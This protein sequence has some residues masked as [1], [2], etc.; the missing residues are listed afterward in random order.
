ME[1]CEALCTKLGI[2]VNGQFQCF[3]NI[4]HLKSKFGKGYSLVIKCKLEIGKDEASLKKN[5]SYV[6]TTES[7]IATNIPNSIL[8]D[9]QQQTLYYQ[10]VFDDE[11]QS[12]GKNA[13][14]LSL[15]QIFNLIET[16]KE[17]LKLETYS[18]SQTSLEQIFLSFANKR[19]DVESEDA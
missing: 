16:N 8:K 6:S 18:L 19:I 13:K 15:A 5:E 11:A 2:M 14:H 1:E 3:G 10:I 12:T 9:K 7:F 4:Q 17:S